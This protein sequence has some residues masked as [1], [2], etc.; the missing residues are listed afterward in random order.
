MYKHVLIDSDCF[1]IVI[2]ELV[3]ARLLLFADLLY[4]KHDCAC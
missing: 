2:H 1:D 4:L 3:I